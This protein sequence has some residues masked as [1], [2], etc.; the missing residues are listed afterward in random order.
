MPFID[1]KA[2]CEITPAQEQ[3]LKTEL[4]KVISL[5]P[6]KSEGVLMISFT[7]HCRM[8]FSGEQDG[9]IAMV[10][11]MIYGSAAREDAS[12]YGNAVAELFR[13]VLGVKHIYCKLEDG[14]D[15]SW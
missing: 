5:I 13:K 3:E 12:A 2:S 9:P 1:V 8:W 6:G 14:T 4:G 7:D 11:T 15:W 10:K